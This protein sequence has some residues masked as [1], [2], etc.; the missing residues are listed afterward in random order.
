[1]EVDIYNALRILKWNQQT[2]QCISQASH[3]SS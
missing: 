3:F 1:M 2:G